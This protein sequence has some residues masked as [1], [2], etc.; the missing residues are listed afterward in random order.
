[1]S[2][3][4]N[5]LGIEFVDTGDLLA[6]DLVNTEIVA[7][8]KLYDLLQ[9]PQDATDWFHAMLTVRMD[10]NR[11][12][13]DNMSAPDQAFLG[14][15]K[16]FRAALHTLLDARLAGRSQSV[17]DLSFVNEVLQN[18][19]MTLTAND[20]QHVHTVYRAESLPGEPILLSCAL[21]AAH[22]LTDLD[23]TR[24]HKCRNPHCVLYFYDRTRSATREWCSIECMDR[25]RSAERYAQLKA[26]QNS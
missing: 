19:R 15:L 6:V 4:K 12:A 9:T 17:G 21:S 24:L 26:S 3:V 23:A 18:A 11:V 1:M 16:T 5:S 2:A 10:E 25:A 14:R 22:L 20:H 8:R 13:L 7:R